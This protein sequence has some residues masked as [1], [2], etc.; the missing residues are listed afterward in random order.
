MKIFLEC[1]YNVD[2]DL[3]KISP[4]DKHLHSILTVRKTQTENSMKN[5]FFLEKHVNACFYFF[6]IFYLRLYVLFFFL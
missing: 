2:G 6:L 3:K 4:F 1:T 5:M